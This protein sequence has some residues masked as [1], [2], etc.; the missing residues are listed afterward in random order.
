MCWNV[1]RE[2]YQKLLSYFTYFRNERF[3]TAEDPGFKRR[4]SWLYPDDGCFAR[5]QMVI[6]LSTQSQNVLPGKI[7]AFGRLRVQTNNHPKGEV[8]WWYHVAPI[9]RVNNQVYVLD[10]S[11]SPKAPLEIYDWLS[12]MS[13]SPMGLQVSFCDSLSYTP[14]SKCNGSSENFQVATSAQKK[15]LSYEWKRLIDLN[16]SPQDEL[17]I[18]PPW[19]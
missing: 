14:Y 4:I 17:G 15:Y 18:N 16:R 19:K 8:R 11:L 5:A 1:I 12:I 2:S 9:A 7:F 10:P 6:K 3:L 13:K